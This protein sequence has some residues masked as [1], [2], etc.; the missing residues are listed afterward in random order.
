MVLIRAELHA[1]A[2]LPSLLCSAACP[3]MPLVACVPIKD[4]GPQ[5]RVPRIRLLERR[6]P[7]VKDLA[8]G[9]GAG[10]TQQPLPRPHLG[11]DSRS[12]Y[13]RGRSTRPLME[14][15]DRAYI[16]MWRW[17]WRLGR[18]F[19]RVVAVAEEAHVLQ[20]THQPREVAPGQVWQLRAAM[21][22]RGEQLQ[23]EGECVGLLELG[24]PQR[25]PRVDGFEA[26]EGASV[27]QIHRASAHGSTGSPHQ[28]DLE[29][30]RQIDRQTDR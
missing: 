4:T 20:Q 26:S 27:E 7:V 22:K 15:S 29:T 2:R 17:G 18:A 6:E 16:A 8:Q 13:S 9:S 28:I 30:D 19:G 12:G 3:Q 24:Q 5:T 11:G 21:G 1:Q 10:P 14:E 23:I 25:R